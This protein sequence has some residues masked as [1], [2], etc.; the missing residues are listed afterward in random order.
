[1]RA[2]IRG[3]YAAAILCFPLLKD[4]TYHRLWTESRIR[5]RGNSYILPLTFMFLLNAFMCIVLV[6]GSL[7]RDGLVDAAHH[8]MLCGPRCA[9][10]F[11]GSTAEELL[12]FRRYQ[13]MTLV[14]MGYAF[15]GWVCWSW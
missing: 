7:A 1:M 5:R 11:A 6:S 10:T 15:L 14:A 8:M 12:A 13:N 3:R 9:D 4:T 2:A